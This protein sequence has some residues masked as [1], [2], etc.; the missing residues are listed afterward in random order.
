MPAQITISFLWEMRCLNE[1]KDLVRQNIS[2]I[3]CDEWKASC[4]AICTKQATIF[5]YLCSQIWNTWDEKYL[6]QSKSSESDILIPH[7]T[8]RKP[9]FLDGLIEKTMLFLSVLFDRYSTVSIVLK[10]R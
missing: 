4:C 3:S 10:F 2:E 5:G 7:S 9:F 1:E 6:G 8:L